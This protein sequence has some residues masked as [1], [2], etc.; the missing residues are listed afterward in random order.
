MTE[1]KIIDAKTVEHVAKLSRLNL[2]PK[3]KDV[4]RKQLADILNY[5]NKLKEV[6]VSKT[7]PTSHPLEGLKNVFRKDTARKSLTADEALRNAPEQKDGFFSVPK[8]ID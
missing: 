6:D 4:Y 8:I 1:K 7:S 5:I 3:E 2:F